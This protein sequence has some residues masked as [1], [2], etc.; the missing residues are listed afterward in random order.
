MARKETN[1]TAETLAEMEAGGDR[2]ADWASDNAAL[3]LGV[4]AG[5]LVLSAG[6]G[7]WLQHSSGERE[8]AANALAVTTS[9]YRQAM[10]AEPGGGPIPEPANAALATETR[11]KFVT[12]FEAVGRDH[13]GTTAGAIAELEAGG[14]Y[15]ALGEPES[16]AQRF[17]SARSA[18]GRTAIGALAAVRVAGL[19]ENQGD[20]RAAAEAFE[21]ASKIEAYPLRASALADAARCWADAGESEKAL[22][23]FQRYEAEFPDE[24]I[25]PQIGARLTELRLRAQL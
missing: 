4:I 23:L 9:Q 17:E 22:A 8:A 10:G 2:L 15:L 5:L 13:V 19:A 1:R 21:A 11:R 25:P 16:A 20:L 14:I 7:F 24:V 6:V 3:I 18:S 12:Q